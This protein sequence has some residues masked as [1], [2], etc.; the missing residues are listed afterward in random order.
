MGGSLV[1]LR[2]EG[3]AVAAPWRIEL[4]EPDI[5]LAVDHLVKV[6]VSEHNDILVGIAAVAT[7]AALGATT[8]T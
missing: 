3:L 2:L 8:V 7:G 4:H 5:I 1:P 6:G